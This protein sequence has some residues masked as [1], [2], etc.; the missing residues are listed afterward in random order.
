MRLG[1][2]KLLEKRE[3]KGLIEKETDFLCI[4]ETKIEEI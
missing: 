3:L 2:Q 1:T 4:Q